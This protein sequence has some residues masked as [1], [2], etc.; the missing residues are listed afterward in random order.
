MLIDA[1][2]EKYTIHFKDTL[3]TSYLIKFLFIFNYSDLLNNNSKN[4][5]TL[6]QEEKKKLYAH[7]MVRT[8][9]RE[10]KLE[11]FF[12]YS[13]SSSIVSNSNSA[14][15]TT[16]NNDATQENDE[17]MSTADTRETSIQTTSSIGEGTT[18]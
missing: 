13:Q 12:P 7:Q 2:A 8:D 3:N 18:K 10:Q 4:A 5:A 6:D 16:T 15:T 9:A 17:I 11:A 14:A 1:H